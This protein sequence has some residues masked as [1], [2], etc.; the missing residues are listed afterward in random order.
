MG[1]AGMAVASPPTPALDKIVAATQD[2]LAVFGQRRAEGMATAEWR[3]ATQG[4]LK[5]SHLA[6]AALAR[7]GFDQLSKSD[8]GFIG[9][10]LRTQYDFLSQFAL[11]VR[12]GD[13]FG[14]QAMARLL[15][16]GAGAVRGTGSAILR[17]DN[18]DGEERNVL[19]G[20][21]SCGECPDLSA[22][23]WVPAG[24]LPEI[25]ERECHGNCNCAIEVRS[26]VGEAE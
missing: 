10:R 2:R 19:G 23:G 8:L 17:R 7:G 15:Q 12:G 11:Q 22:Q 25:G 3:L 1:G 4:V 6:A 5:D 20:G 13:D 18:A 14:G 26:S 16:Y 21:E 9:S 24:T